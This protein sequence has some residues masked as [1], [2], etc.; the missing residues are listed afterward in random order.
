MLDD[1]PVRADHRRARSTTL[2]A[3]GGIP[4]AWAQI[5]RNSPERVPQEEVADGRHI[6][7]ATS[8]KSTSKLHSAAE[9]PLRALASPMSG[10]QA[11]LRS[12]K[13]VA[14]AFRAENALR[15]K[16]ALVDV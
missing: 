8:W 6:P 7:A 10:R 14:G 1:V 13:V 2:P 15:S 12:T 11:R 5:L 16:M 4:R 3:D 9:K